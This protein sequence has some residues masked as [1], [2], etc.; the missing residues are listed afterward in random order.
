MNL[1]TLARAK[2]YLGG[3]MGTG[4]D[5]T[6]S[7]LI[8]RASDQA[9]QF[10]SRKF[11]RST[12]TNAKL[13]GTGTRRLMLPDNPIISVTDPIT[14][15]GGNISASADG[16]A[17]GF[18]YDEK[19]LYLFG[20][21]EFCRGLRNVG[22][23][24]VAG[25]TTT[26]TDYI[27]A[28]PGPYTIAPVV[29]SG[30]GVDGTPTNTAGPALVD[31]GVTN[32]ST[33]AALVKVSS[34]PATGQYSFADGIYTFAAADAG[35]SVTMSYDFVPGS[36]EQAVLEMTGA[37]LKRRDNLGVSSRTLANEVVSYESKMLTA[38]VKEMLQP[39]RFVVAP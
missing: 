37:M 13:N 1:T 23:S 5:T 10:T 24:W 29:G 31:R 16:L 9:M 17:L 26:E 36:V 6:L 20:G 7:A 21:A 11:Q 27:P 4:V 39:Y 22:V 15:N 30:V 3:N 25:Y 38:A 34:A 18:Q 19:F 28:A 12:Y 35:V 14:I 2:S 32:A 33:G 8:S